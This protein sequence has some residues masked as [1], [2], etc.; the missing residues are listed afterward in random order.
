MKGMKFSTETSEVE[1]IPLT[2]DLAN[3]RAV[4]HTKILQGESVVYEFGGVIT[5]QLEKKSEWRVL[6]GHTSTPKER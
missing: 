5:W 3:A 2:P 1:V 6:T 4:F